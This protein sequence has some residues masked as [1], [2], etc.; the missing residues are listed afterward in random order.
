MTATAE[1]FAHL[2]SASR[3]H[4]RRAYVRARARI[5]R[6]DLA[7]GALAASLKRSGVDVTFH[8]S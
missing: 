3:R 8:S 2:A 5:H 4:K 7:A 6:L 1:A